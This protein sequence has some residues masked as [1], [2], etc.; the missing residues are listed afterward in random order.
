MSV[1][2]FHD[3][4]DFYVHHSTGYCKIWSDCLSPPLYVCTRRLSFNIIWDM[5][6]INDRYDWLLK[7]MGT[8]QL[9]QSKL[10]QPIH[11]AVVA[12]SHHSHLPIQSII[13]QHSSLQGSTSLYYQT[14]SSPKL[15]E[16]SAQPYIIGIVFSYVFLS[17][18]L[19]VD[20]AY[21]QN[22]CSSWTRFF[23]WHKKVYS[24]IEGRCW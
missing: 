21:F 16:G 8:S 12:I 17:V 9:C 6:V 15:T 4:F 7:W 11:I 19:S 2:Q 10:F 13:L 5:V 20:K 1:S 3:T 24:A 18:V 22:I 14:V 23:A